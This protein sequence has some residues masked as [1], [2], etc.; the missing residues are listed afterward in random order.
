MYI[1]WSFNY[2]FRY[3]CK[4]KINLKF[5][6]YI[7]KCSHAFLQ[8]LEGRLSYKLCLASSYCAVCVYIMS[9]VY[10]TH[11]WFHILPISVL[12]EIKGRNLFFFIR[13]TLRAKL[14]LNHLSTCYKILFLHFP[15]KLSSDSLLNTIYVNFFC[16]NSNRKQEIFHRKRHE[17]PQCRSSL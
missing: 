14:K 1:K 13:S 15:S 5:M 11:F 6:D 16:K 2:T 17:I 12:S 7:L 4:V 10:W 8:I 3:E 9:I